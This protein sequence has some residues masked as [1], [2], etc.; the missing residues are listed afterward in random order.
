MSIYLIFGLAVG[1]AMDAFAVAVSTGMVLPEITRRHYFRLS[2]HFGLFQGLMPLL[3]WGA[4]R[5]FASYITSADHWIA[6]GLLSLIGGRMIYESFSSGGEI[7][8]TAVKKDPTR[9][10]NLVVLSVAT[11]VDAFAIGLS[12]ALLGVKIVLPALAIGMITG[13]ITFLGMKLGKHLGSFLGNWIEKIGGLI[14]IGIG[15]KILIEHLGG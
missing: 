10:L 4:G 7:G 9:G 1:L 3:G 2:F 8:G 15:I 5:T 14:L 11:S 12:L 13:L 6:F